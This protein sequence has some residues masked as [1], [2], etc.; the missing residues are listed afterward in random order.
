MKALR[1]RTGR[2]DEGS[3]IYPGFSTEE[4]VAQNMFLVVGFYW[5]I[6]N[7]GSSYNSEEK[8]FGKFLFCFTSWHMPGNGS[9]P[10][11]VV[12]TFPKHHE[13]KMLLCF[14]TIQNFARGGFI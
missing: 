12:E 6:W 8:A 11:F 3:G 10:A 5:R 1:I 7:P 2:Y 9:I 14:F 13:G 4:T